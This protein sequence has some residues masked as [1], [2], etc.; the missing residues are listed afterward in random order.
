MGITNDN[1]WNLG[2]FPEHQ[3]EPPV[4]FM[5]ADVPS[6]YIKPKKLT[7]EN[8][9]ELLKMSRRLD[10]DNAR[11]SRATETPRQ[12]TTITRK[13]NS[14]SKSKKAKGKQQ[15][16]PKLSLTTKGFKRHFTQHDYHDYARMHPAQLIDV[17]DQI[18]SSRGGVH[19]PFPTVLHGM[20]EEAEEKGFTNVISWQPHG[21][22]FLILEPKLFVAEVLPEYFKHSKL[23]S[24]QRQLSLYGFVRLTHDGPDRGSYYHECFLRG[25][26]FLCPRIQRTRI[27]G[28]WVRT[29]SSPESEPNFYAMEPVDDLEKMGDSHSDS[30]ETSS[31]M[32]SSDSESMYGYDE[33]SLEDEEMKTSPI[34]SS[35]EAPMKFLG[36]YALDSG[37]CKES[38]NKP[39]AETGL[40]PPPAFP[41]RVIGAANT[42]GR[43]PTSTAHTK[44][45]ER[46]EGK[47]LWPLKLPANDIASLSKF[48][49]FSL[50]PL[51]DDDELALF[52]TDVDLDTDLDN[53]D[54]IK[55]TAV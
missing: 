29:S 17:V 36:F 25:R 51:L 4:E 6:A 42:R 12:A 45:S 26:P 11:W 10:D 27:K 35:Q 39:P 30:R 33:S 52:L 20:M 15:G 13:R 1:D 31:S 18:K 22:T 21:R 44:P 48:G 23:S 46:I 16:G 19:H 37:E 54:V 3:D 5:V 50:P 9:A 38:I 40:L 28:T 41:T 7:K 53:E 24:F 49:Q 32:N 47:A 43:R 34:F 55:I 14:N 8:G 2:S